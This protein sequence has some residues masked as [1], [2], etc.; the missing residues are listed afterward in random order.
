[1][2]HADRFYEL[3]KAIFMRQAALVAKWMQVGF[4]HGVMN[5]DNV[6]VSGESIDFGP[7]AFMNSYDPSTVYSSIDQDGRYSYGAQPGVMMWNLTRLTES[8]MP[9]LDDDSDRALARAKKL[10]NLFPG[11]FN[12]EWQSCIRAK[13][14][15][16]TSEAGDDAI[17]KELL[18]EMVSSKLDFT[19]T[20]RALSGDSA[21]TLSDKLNKWRVGWESRIAPARNQRSLA[22]TFASMRSTNPAVIARNGFVEEA[23]KQGVEQG[24]FSYMNSLVAALREPF[25]SNAKFSIAESV[26]EP[27]YR[28]FCGT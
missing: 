19:A 28:T 12:S 17:I 10:V 6:A 15:F 9:I 23:I 16:V 22:D 7:C 24:D 11:Y 27:E 2:D 8:V 14:G 18:E 25:V 3:A 21:F 13:L 5:T 4:I 1:M 26:D 20:F